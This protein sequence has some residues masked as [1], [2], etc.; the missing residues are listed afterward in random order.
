MKVF[1]ASLILSLLAVG[2]VT[3]DAA[4]RQADAAFLAGQRSVLQKTQSTGVTVLGT[5]QNPAVPWVVGL[6]L[7]QAIATANYLERSE[8]KSLI[9]IRQGER[10]EIDPQRLLDGVAIPL[11]PGDVIEIR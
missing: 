3:K 2:C 4:R 10:A 7:A 1:C 5:V 6:T 9:I 11:E 8:P